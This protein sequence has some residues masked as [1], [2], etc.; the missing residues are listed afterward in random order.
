[1]EGKAWYRRGKIGLGAPSGVRGNSL[2]GEGMQTWLGVALLDKHRVQ[3]GTRGR[4]GEATWHP[5]IVIKIIS[6]LTTFTKNGM[7]IFT[8]LLVG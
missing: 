7:T 3:V 8:N 2:R 5:A 6:H 1:M 4:E